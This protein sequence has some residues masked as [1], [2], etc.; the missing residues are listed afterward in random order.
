MSLGTGPDAWAAWLL[1]STRPPTEI[2][3]GWAPGEERELTRCVR[4]SYRLDLIAP[5]QPV[6]LW[7]SGRVLP[8]VHAVGT[9]TGALREDTGGD[10]GPALP[11]RLTRLPD[12]VERGELLADPHFRTA[13]VLRMPAGSNPSW[14]SAAQ[15]EAVLARAGLQRLGRWTP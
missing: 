7:V 4:R 15:L 8:G 12:P 2:D 9:V 3:P 14:L 1:K 13:E 6:L 5:G 11:V 10:D